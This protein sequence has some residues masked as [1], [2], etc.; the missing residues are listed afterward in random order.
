MNDVFRYLAKKLDGTPD[1]V[2]PDESD[3]KLK[4]LGRYISLNK[5]K[6]PSDLEN[7]NAFRAPFFFEN[8]ISC[9]WIKSIQT[10]AYCYDW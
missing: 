10:F 6:W 7:S 8:S 1:S 2:L 9:V 3:V 4:V 5:P